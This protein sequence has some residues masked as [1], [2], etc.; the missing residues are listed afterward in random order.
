MTCVASVLCLQFFTV[1]SPTKKDYHVDDGN[2]RK[3]RVDTKF[4]DKLKSFIVMLV[5]DVISFPEHL[6][7]I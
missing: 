3:Q 6:S 4:Q 2:H 5:S 7:W 1:P